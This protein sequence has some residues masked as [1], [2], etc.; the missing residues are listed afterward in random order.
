MGCHFLFHGIFLTPGSNLGLLNGRQILYH[1]SYRKVPLECSISGV[2]VPVI[3]FLPSNIYIGRFRSFLLNIH[4]FIAKSDIETFI[5]KNRNFRVLYL[6][7]I[8]L[9]TLSL[10]YFLVFF[11]FSHICPSSCI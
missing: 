2:I 8:R 6:V 5:N 4:F 3:S 10:T 1:M 9:D 7:I 11:Y